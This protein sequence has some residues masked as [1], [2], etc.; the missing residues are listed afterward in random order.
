[1]A[2]AGIRDGR[3]DQIENFGS[4]FHWSLTII[5]YP[6]PTF[7]IDYKSIYRCCL[8]EGLNVAAFNKQVRFSVL[9]SHKLN[10]CT[11]RTSDLRQNLVRHGALDLS[12]HRCWSLIT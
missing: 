10:S 7:N 6:V 3:I 8:L 2:P 4:G 5:L 9:V 12:T 1:M 11:S